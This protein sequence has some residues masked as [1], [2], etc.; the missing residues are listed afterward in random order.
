MAASQRRALGALFL[1]L[2][3]FFTGIAL[4]AFSSEDRTVWVVGVAAGVI[5]LWLA[6][7]AFKGLRHR[8]R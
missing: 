8:A 3:V 2:A 1:V 5:A 4:T 6:G 7:M